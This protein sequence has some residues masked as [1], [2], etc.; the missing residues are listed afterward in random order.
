MLIV[1]L[2]DSWTRNSS[3]AAVCIRLDKHGNVRW[4]HV[5]EGSRYQQFMTAQVCSDGGYII[6]G[7][8]F[9]LGGSNTSFDATLTKY[10]AAGNYQW[11]HK[12]RR[13]GAEIIYGVSQTPDGG[14]AMVGVGNSTQIGF[15]SD[16]I[17]YKTNASGNFQWART[18]GTLQYEKAWGLTI[19]GDSSYYIAA[20][21]S[22]K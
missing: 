3:E 2:S 18:Y 19:G 17:L 8:A 10:D 11:T 6:A 15:Q 21:R 12:F 14:Y 13:A 22:Y 16:I 5:V 20:S 4:Q 1:G 7:Q 9:A